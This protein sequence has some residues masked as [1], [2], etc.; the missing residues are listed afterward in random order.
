MT[1]VTTPI[2]LRGGRSQRVGVVGALGAPLGGHA[3]PSRTV[4]ARSCSGQA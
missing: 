3:W 4:R 1:E 2:P